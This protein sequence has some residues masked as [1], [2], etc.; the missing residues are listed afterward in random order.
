MFSPLPMRHVMLQVMTDELPQA[1]LTLAELAV[2]SPDHR[3]VHEESFPDIPGQHFRELYNQ[4][5]SRLE[6]IGRHIT[7]PPQVRLGQIHVISEQDLQKTNDWL[8]EVWERC[9][10]LEEMLRD[11]QEEE[12]MI[13]QLEQAL[14]NFS[15]LN[16]DLSLLRDKRLFLDLR[17]GM[18]PRTNITQLR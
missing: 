11:L 16:I 4:A 1:S 17:I 2:F 15:H 12:Q 3:P 5:G 7:L 8:G 6:K 13:H 14:E 10:A 18:V 9:S